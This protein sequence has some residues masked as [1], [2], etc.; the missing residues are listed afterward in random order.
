MTIFPLE[1][2]TDYAPTGTVSTHLI[3]SL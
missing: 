2:N 3:T 1:K